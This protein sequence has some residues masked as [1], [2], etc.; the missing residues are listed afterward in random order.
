M[1]LNEL[2]PMNLPVEH[3]A[4][5]L[6]ALAIFQALWFWIGRH[7]RRRTMRRK[8]RQLLREALIKHGLDENDPRLKSFK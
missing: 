1:P 8:A 2:R 7:R 3:W 5:F 6:S 4:A